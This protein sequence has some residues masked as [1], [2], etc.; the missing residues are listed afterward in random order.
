MLDKAMVLALV[1]SFAVQKEAQLRQ[2]ARVPS[3]EPGSLPR[4]ISQLK[5]C[6]EEDSYQPS[7]WGNV[8]WGKWGL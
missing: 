7:R 2:G 5:A 4:A 6:Q 3:L 8:H 1:G